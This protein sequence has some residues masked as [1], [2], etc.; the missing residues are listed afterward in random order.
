VGVKLELTSDD[1]CDDA[2]H[3]FRTNM[4][5]ATEKS[6]LGSDIWRLPNN[7]DVIEAVDLRDQSSLITSCWLT[8]EPAALADR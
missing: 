7:G 1:L 2:M 8:Y 4:G 3:D 6:S 5:Q